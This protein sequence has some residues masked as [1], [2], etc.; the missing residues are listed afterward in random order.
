MRSLFH[1]F[2]MLLLAALLLLSLVLN[3]PAYAELPPTP[4]NGPT[5]PGPTSPPI[6]PGTIPTPSN[7]PLLNLFLPLVIH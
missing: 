4:N 2:I 1:L 3:G 7:A 5:S 6:T